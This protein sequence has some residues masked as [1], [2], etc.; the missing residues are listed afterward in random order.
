[1]TQETF[2]QES[3][4][5]PLMHIEG[6]VGGF[7][8]KLSNP[9]SLRV[10]EGA[11]NAAGYSPD[12]MSNILTNIEEENQEKAIPLLSEILNGEGDKKSKAALARQIELM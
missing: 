9:E 1:M 7:F 11:F 12:V 4:P 2:S 6:K 5:N 8:K 10:L 3:A